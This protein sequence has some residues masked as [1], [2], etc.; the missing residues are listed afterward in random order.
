MRILC[1]ALE[2]IQEFYHLCCI[3]NIFTIMKMIVLISIFFR[4][5]LIEDI[6][7]SQFKE[8]SFTELS[9]F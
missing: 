8:L 1:F 9:I 6:D 2:F 5:V 7:I 4:N 3:S